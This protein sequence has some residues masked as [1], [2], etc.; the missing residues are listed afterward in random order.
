MK[1][2]SLKYFQSLSPKKRDIFGLLS[3][4]FQTYKTEWVYFFYINSNQICGKF[5]FWVCVVRRVWKK[6]HFCFSC[7]CVWQNPCDGAASSFSLKIWSW[8]WTFPAFFL[9]WC[10]L[11]CHLRRSP[12]CSL[13][14]LWRNW[15]MDQE[16]QSDPNWKIFYLAINL[17][18]KVFSWS[19]LLNRLFQMG[20]KLILNLNS[21]IFSRESGHVIKSRCD[22][23]LGFPR[24]YC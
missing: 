24:K 1:P 15:S 12:N 3:L 10:L 8:F 19:R 4:N 9:L 20:I 6:Y 17:N 2:L 14:L 16:K 13:R 7:F 23:M 21:M 22:C 5:P 18:L 11:W